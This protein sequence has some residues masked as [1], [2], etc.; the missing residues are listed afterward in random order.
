MKHTEL[1]D[2]IEEAFPSSLVEGWDNSGLQI[3]PFDSEIRRVG[4]ALNPSFHSI[5]SAAESNCDFLITHHPLFFCPLKRIDLSTPVGKSVS[6]ALCNR[7]TV[8]SLHTPWDSAVG[9]G[10]D[11]WADLLGLQNRAPIVP[12]PADPRAGMGRIG[13]IGE[14]SFE[15]IVSHLKD[16]VS[17]LIPVFAGRERISKVAV[18]MGS[19]G[20]LLGRVRELSAHLFITADLKYHQIL[21][22]VSFK[23]NLIIMSHHEMEERTLPKLA[24]HVRKLAPELDVQVILERDPLSG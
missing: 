11:F 16:S 6:L 22:A 1:I 14:I 10:N 4:V 3:G 7:I 8:Y 18:C 23:I 9:G 2:L 12:A 17:F 5:A 21:E 15:E 13:E 20:D 24:D 19:C